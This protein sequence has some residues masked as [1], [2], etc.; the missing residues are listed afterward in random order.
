VKVYRVKDGVIIQD[1]TSAYSIET[2]WDELINREDLASYL[3]H[4]VDAGLPLAASDFGRQILHCQPGSLGG[5]RH[6][7][8]KPYGAHRR[9][10]NGRRRGFLRPRLFGGA[11]GA[12]L[13]GNRAPRRRPRRGGTHPW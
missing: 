3:R 12:L 11:P 9:V 8:P 1:G 5:R 7:L 6:L 13:Q 2:D 10:A 4:L